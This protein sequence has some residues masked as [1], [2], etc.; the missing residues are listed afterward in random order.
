MLRAMTGTRRSEARGHRQMEHTADVALEMWA[1]AEE[2]LLEEAAQAVIG[3]LTGGLVPPSGRRRSVT[4][5]A[6]DPE[7]R[8]VSF[9]NEVLALAMMDGYLVRN[10]AIRLE[11]EGGLT[12]DLDGAADASSMV[13]TELKMVTYHHLLLEQSHGRWYGRVVVDV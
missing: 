11:G 13:R 4:I 12:A 1:P 7:D 8:L 2:D 3:I 5:Q 10:A 6:M 9:M